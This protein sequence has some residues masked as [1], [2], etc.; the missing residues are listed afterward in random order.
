M[1]S[2]GPAHWGALSPT[3]RGVNGRDSTWED[4]ETAIDAN[5]LPVNETR[6]RTGEEGHRLGDLIA[7]TEYELI[8]A[9]DGA[10]GVAA[11]ER[12]GQT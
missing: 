2:R 9:S 6:A 12:T 8:E 5:D 4:G 10:A 3:V 11:A 1:G 7:T